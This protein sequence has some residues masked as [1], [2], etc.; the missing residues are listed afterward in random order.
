VQGT[1]QFLA[2]RVGQGGLEALGGEGQQGRR[3]GVGAL[4]EVL[5]K[6][7]LAKTKAQRIDFRILRLRAQKRLQALPGGQ[8]IAGREV[9][10][11]EPQRGFAEEFG[12][13]GG[14]KILRERLGGTLGIAQFQPELA[15]DG[16]G[17]GTA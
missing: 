7:S 15:D 12:R 5:A 9:Q 14:R 16:N 4:L 11:G 3:L 17:L 8:E 6:Q 1:L 2:R 13:R 10:F